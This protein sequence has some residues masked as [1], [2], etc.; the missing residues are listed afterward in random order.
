MS[1]ERI[2]ITID[3][4]LLSQLDSLVAGSGHANRSEFLRDLIRDR[5]VEESRAGEQVAGALAIVYDHGQTLLSRE[6]TETAHHHHHQVLATLHVHL[7]PAYCME[8]T[9]LRGTR[10]ELEHYAEHVRGMKGVMSGDL[11]IVQRLDTE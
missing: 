7:T 4:D 9:A 10:H 3:R 6:L 11:S 5:L 8:L 1:L 2:S